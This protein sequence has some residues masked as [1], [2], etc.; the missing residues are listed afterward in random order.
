[1]SFLAQYDKA[2]TESQFPLV[3]GWMKN[4]PLEFFTELRETRPILQTPECTLLALHDDVVDALLQPSVFT[5]QL[6]EDKMGTH[7]MAQDDTAVH[8]REK[9]IMQSL[10][11]R[12]DLPRIRQFVGETASAALDAAPDQEIEAINGLTRRV[13]I[14]LVQEYMQL[15]RSAV[16]Y[17]DP[18][19]CINCR[20]RSTELLWQCP[21]CHEWNTFVEE[22]SAPAKEVT[23]ELESA[24]E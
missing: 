7:L 16:F 13:P 20:Y 24:R 15:T 19:I 6:Y 22:R 2:T 3:R 8:Y 23:A 21:Q 17:L 11:N 12:D 9:A 18:H 1:M 14:A 4:S 10:L 5:V